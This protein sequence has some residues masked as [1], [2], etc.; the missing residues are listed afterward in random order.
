MKKRYE[1]TSLSKDN[2]KKIINEIKY[3]KTTLTFAQQLEDL[4]PTIDALYTKKKEIREELNKF[5]EQIAEKETEIEA[6]RKQFED[7]K[8]LRADL[9][10]QIDKF[11]EQY[12]V[13]KEEL[14][15]LYEKKNLDKEAYY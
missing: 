4:K 11:E 2:E 13:K 7:A 1:T 10:E 9:Q 5:K 12:Q 15:K 6:V 14:N 8:N 3:L